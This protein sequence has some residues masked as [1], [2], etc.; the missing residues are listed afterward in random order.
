[1]PLP[2]SVALVALP[3]LD[4]VRL[5]TWRELSQTACQLP[6]FPAA[7]AAQLS[8][9]APPMCRP[10]AR[11]LRLHSATRSTKGKDRAVQHTEARA[12]PHLLRDFV[13]TFILSTD[14]NLHSFGAEGRGLAALGVLGGVRLGGN[15]SRRQ[16]SAFCV[17]CRRTV[18]G[19]SNIASYTCADRNA[20]LERQEPR[21]H[22]RAAAERSSLRCAR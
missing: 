15:G 5:D 14:L 10:E 1:M 13:I 6:G 3:I 22:S 17:S 7:S 21:Q 4:S 2:P 8:G 19:L 12:S 9:P 11:Q 16:G 18:F 20:P